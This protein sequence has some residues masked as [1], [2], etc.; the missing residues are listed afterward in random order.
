MAMVITDNDPSAGYVSWTGVVM[1]FKSVDYSVTNGNSNKKFI[2]WDFTNPNDFQTSDT[3]PTL[4]DDD[5]V[6]IL[7]KSGTH[8]LIPGSSL[9]F[10]DLL[11]EEADD[12]VF[13]TGIICLWYGSVAS[14][15]TGWYLC[16]GSNS[17]PDLRDTFVVGAKQDDSGVAKTNLTGSLT[18]SGG[19]LT[20]STPSLHSGFQQTGGD[21]AAEENHTHTATPPYYAL[22]YIMKA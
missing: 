14:I 9:S 1:T 21:N 3:L 16:D 15:P 7:N 19:S 8:Y 11:V 12:K 20:T 22:C 17:T 5:C 13:P 10:N 18:Q 6:F 4:T 2:W